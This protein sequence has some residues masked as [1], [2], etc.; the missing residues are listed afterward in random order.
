VA[1]TGMHRGTTT[2]T[3]SPQAAF[4]GLGISA[5]QDPGD[6]GRTI[7]T[8]GGNYR[9]IRHAEIL[10]RWPVLP[11]EWARVIEAGRLADR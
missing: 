11:E 7:V 4:M 5:E 10:A 3:G 8:R 9:H 2:S 6:P 1:D